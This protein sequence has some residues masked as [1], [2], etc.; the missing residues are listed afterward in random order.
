MSVIGTPVVGLNQIAYDKR[1]D[2]SAKNA[3]AS[4]SWFCGA[5]KIRGRRKEAKARKVGSLAD[6]EALP[7]RYRASQ[8]YFGNFL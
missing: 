1:L 8:M 2:F 4:G 7:E 3:L 5:L 6:L